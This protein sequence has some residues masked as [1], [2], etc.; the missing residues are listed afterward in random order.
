V[1]V[2]LLWYLK[3]QDVELELWL[4]IVLF[5]GQQQTVDLCLYWLSELD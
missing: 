4:P 3:K 2:L 5:A 1:R